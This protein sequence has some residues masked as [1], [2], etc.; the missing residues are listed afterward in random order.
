MVVQ[1][2]IE[3]AVT[4]PV[5]AIGIRT[6]IEEGIELLGIFLCLLAGLRLRGAACASH[7]AH[8]LFR[9]DEVSRPFAIATAGLALHVAFAFL[10]PR[11]G[12]YPGLGNPAMWFPTAAYG[13]AAAM[14]VGRLLRG[15]RFDVLSLGLIAA[16]A[17]LSAVHAVFIYPESSLDK[18]VWRDAAGAGAGFVA[19]LFARVVPRLFLAIYLLPAAALAAF[20]VTGTAE[21]A[22]LV[23]GAS[24]WASLIAC[25]ALGEAPVERDT[26][27]DGAT[28]ESSV[29]GVA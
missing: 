27:A 7:P 15:A 19:L 22:F 26:E 23:A 2:I 12:G 14:L 5:W 29:P 16:F 17:L 11:L 18:L 3:H 20:V 25:R 6:G 21:S 10:A 9:I 4:W 8:A 24:A 1:E 28:G 13:L